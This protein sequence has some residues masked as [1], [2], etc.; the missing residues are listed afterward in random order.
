MTCSL[1]FPGW[2]SQVASL[3]KDKACTPGAFAFDALQ[4][5]GCLSFSVQKSE[6]A[7]GAWNRGGSAAAARLSR[8]TCEPHPRVKEHQLPPPTII[9]RPAK[10]FKRCADFRIWNKINQRSHRW[11]CGD[12]FFQNHNGFAGHYAKKSWSNNPGF[13]REPTC[14]LD[15]QEIE[16]GVRESW[17]ETDRERSTE[18]ERLQA[19][20][21]WSLVH[22]PDTDALCQVVEMTC[23]K[24]LPDDITVTTHHFLPSDT[25]TVAH[26]KYGDCVAVIT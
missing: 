13:G 14:G 16:E 2:L 26:F 25:H 15:L 11:F 3:I 5:M 22:Y 20:C 19:C 8:V 12:Y 21:L 1:L 17:K 6:S 9:S 24:H 10:Q 23:E 7:Q 18:T 4:H